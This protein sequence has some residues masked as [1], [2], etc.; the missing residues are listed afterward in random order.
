MAKE[1]W[2]KIRDEDG[3]TLLYSNET[4]EVIRGNDLGDYKVLSL[5]TIKK[6]K[7]AVE[8][9]RYEKNDSEKFFWYIYDSNNTA[10]SKL[11]T[12][13]VTMLMYLCTFMNYQ[14]YLKTNHKKY[15]TRDDFETLLN[16]KQRE[17]YNFYN[18]LIN[19]NIITVEKTDD[20]TKLKLNENIF[21]K[22]K[23]DK[24]K[25]DAKTFS[26]IRIY[27]SV[28][29]KLYSNRVCKK[30]MGYF[31]KLI[32]YVHETNNLLCKN[33]YETNKNKIQGLTL[34]DICEILNYSKSNTLK[35]KRILSN[36]TFIH[37]DIKQCVFKQLDYSADSKQSKSKQ[38][39]FGI[40]PLLFYAGTVM[41]RIDISNQYCIT[42]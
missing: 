29:Q 38:I 42:N 21:Y 12:S 13:H 7:Y 32:P 18:T 8:K 31:Y 2:T 9:K 26:A 16:I 20:E 34:N 10:L 22:G 17:S 5:D 28:I 35:L 33:K 37:N 1:V 14:N 23:F 30:R 19:N 39:M 3:N 36:I 27:N 15:I 25:V 4:G 24:N 11:K 6:Q 40:N 41:D